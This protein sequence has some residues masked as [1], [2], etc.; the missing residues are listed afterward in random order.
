MSSKLST[1]AR[2][3]SQRRKEGRRQAGEGVD[4]SGQDAPF[5]GNRESWITGSEHEGRVTGKEEYDDEDEEE[6][7]SIAPNGEHQR[8]REEVVA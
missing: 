1:R 3:L 5:E 8:G 2:T 7:E 6:D 4:L